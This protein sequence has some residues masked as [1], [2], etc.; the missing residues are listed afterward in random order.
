MQTPK[1]T[2]VLTTPPYSLTENFGSLDFAG[3]YGPPI[4]LIYLASSLTKAGIDVQLVDFSYE[5]KSLEECAQD[6]MKFNPDFVGLAVHFTFLAN[7]AM[8][9]ASQIKKINPKIKIIAGGVHFT[10]CPE[11][12]MRDCPAID[13]GIMGEAEAALPKIILE[14]QRGSHPNTVDGFV[15]R[16]EG[17]KIILSP[18]RGFIE[19]VNQLPFPRFDLIKHL[20][21]TLALHKDREKLSIPLVTSRGCPFLCRFCDRTVLGSKIRFFSINYLSEMIEQLVLKHQVTY[22]DIEDENIGVARKR[23]MEI[24]DLLKEKHETHGLTWSCSLRAD[25]VDSETGDRLYASGCRTISFGI[26]S[27]SKE[28]LKIYNK[29]LDLDQ[30]PEKCQIITRAN[31]TLGGSLIIGGPGE[32]EQSIMDTI[33]LIKKINLSFMYVWYFV[34]FPGSE[35]FHNIETH[36]KLLGDF[37]TRTGQHISFIP[38][39]LS[40]EQLEGGYRRIYQAFYSKPSVILRT[41]KKYGWKHSFKFCHDGARYAARFLFR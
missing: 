15:Y 37:S 35:I 32:N 14:L 36:G 9:L 41:F 10:A 12:T 2:V 39:S 1:T 3:Q 34:P 21:Y 23:F 28:M 38:N 6:L 33:N 31:I 7:K 27:G 29:K 8:A 26:E 24:C 20:P 18:Q 30:L 17:N 22:L 13:M 11:Q 40:R 16:G 5:K 19:D 25:N 4:N